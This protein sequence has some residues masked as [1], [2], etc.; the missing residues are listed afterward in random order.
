MVGTDATGKE[1][2]GG[3]FAKQTT[4]W[5]SPDANV[6]QDGETPET[7][8]ARQELIKAEKINGNGMGTPLAMAAQIWMAELWPPGPP[9]REIRWRGEKFSRTFLGSLRAHRLR[10]SGRPHLLRLLQNMGRFARDTFGK[11]AFGRR[12]LNPLFVRWL[13]GFRPTESMS[14]EAWETR[15]SQFVAQWLSAFSGSRCL[16]P[17]LTQRLLFE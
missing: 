11:P 12:R 5:P 14:F 8:L 10:L 13:M 16:E 15:W 1:G 7:F 9:D 17:V 2:H 4:Q 3:E 6:F